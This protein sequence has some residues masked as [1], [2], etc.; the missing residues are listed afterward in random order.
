MTTL[1]DLGNVRRVLADLVR[2][3]VQS[4]SSCGR[5]TGMR[6]GVVIVMAACVMFC[7]GFIVATL[8]AEGAGAVKPTC[9]DPRRLWNVSICRTLGDG[10][11][12]T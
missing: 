2:P 5:L 11:V 3:S 6:I 12:E 4:H 7:G 8:A 1:S 10:G 9:K